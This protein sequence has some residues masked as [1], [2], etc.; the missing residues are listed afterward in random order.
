MKT[1]YVI[2]HAKSSWKNT[3]QT[4]FERPLND[5]G[6]RDVLEMGNRLVSK[7]IS[8]DCIIASAAV[9][10]TKTSRKLAKQINFPGK[11][12]QFNDDLYLCSTKTVL[13]VVN[14]ISDKHQSVFIV[15]HN[16]TMSDFCDY[17][18]GVIHPFPTL[19]IA[20]IEFDI[21]SW[22]MVSGGTGDLKWIDFPKNNQ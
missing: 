11:E 17:L 8:P 1:L 13:G 2:R 6:K 20:K 10:T 9:R 19:A 14:N 5:R 4:D 7:R 12:I 16:P 21:D 18:T 22:Q 15:G 3:S